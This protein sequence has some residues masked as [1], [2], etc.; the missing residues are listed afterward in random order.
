VQ[1]VLA[2]LSWAAASGAVPP[3]CLSVTCC[4]LLVFCQVSPGLPLLF[5][6][7]P[8]TSTPEALV[9]GSTDRSMG[10]GVR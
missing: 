7:F 8:P 10:L 9:T 6:V 1:Q 3:N 2:E 4:H 5:L